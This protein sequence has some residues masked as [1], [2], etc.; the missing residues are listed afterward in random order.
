MHKL[1]VN[2]EIACHGVELELEFVGVCRY[3][4]QPP[5]LHAEPSL[6]SLFVAS[7]LQMN[8]SQRYIRL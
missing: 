1:G 6:K 4:T 3:S 7:C 5:R 2:Q 8:L